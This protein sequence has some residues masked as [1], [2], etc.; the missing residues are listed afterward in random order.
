MSK[1][2]VILGVLVA[3]LVAFL[4]WWWWRRRSNAAVKLPA[5]STLAN[6]PGVAAAWFSNISAGARPITA[7]SGLG[8]SNVY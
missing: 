4:G 5:V 6:P 8:L 3:A 7:L 2:K 1:D